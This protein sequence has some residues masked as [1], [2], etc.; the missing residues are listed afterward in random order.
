MKKSSVPFLLL[1]SVFLL[2]GCILPLQ[3]TSPDPV[4]SIPA[5]EQISEP[6]DIISS[7]PVPG[8]VSD[9]QSVPQLS[10][11][12]SSAIGEPNLAIFWYAMAD[13]HVFDLREQFGPV[14]EASGISY[15]E[16]DAE[17]DRYRQLDQIREAVAGGWNI[18]AIQLVAD[19]SAEEARAMIDLASECPILFFDRVPDITAF[20]DMLSNH[21]GSAGVICTDPAE[22]GRVQGRMIGEYLTGHFSSVDLNQNGQISYTLLLGN[23]DDP[24]AQVHSRSV[25]DT[26]NSI[27]TAEGYRSLV[28][29]DEDNTLG[30]Q[31]SPDG[32]RTSSVG[33]ALIRADLESYNYTNSNM[34]ELIAAGNDDMALGA[35]TA[36]QASWC[37]LGDGSSVTIPLFGAGASNAARTAVSLGQ[38]TGTVDLNAA[39][40]ARAVVSTVQGLS[41]G[42][43]MTEVF[44]SI[45]SSSNEFSLPENPYTVL[46]VS[47]LPV[48]S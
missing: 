31:F 37:N 32:A 35:L 16:Y 22:L 15:R 21:G 45:S 17:N 42:Q 36:L 30:F 28:F 10:S 14:L 43:T 5:S 29:L 8:S 11:P 20:H 2:S 4:L 12:G 40:Y 23:P 3:H 33:T 41:E 34:I 7:A 48:L 47:P 44:S 9:L 25:L 13:A 6:E 38:M 46:C 39:G 24:A 27:L 26:A 18:L 1:I 19:G